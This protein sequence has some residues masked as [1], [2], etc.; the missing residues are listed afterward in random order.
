[1]NRRLWDPL[2][3]VPI[4]GVTG[5]NGA[6]K[7]LLAVQSALADLQRGRVVYSTTPIHSRWGDSVPITSIS[8]LLDLP[9]GC[10]VLIDEVASV[11]S[12]RTSTGLPG[13]FDLF[14]QVLRHRGIAFR[15]TAP[16]WLRAD[17]RLREVTQGL[18]AVSPL[19]RRP[20]PE[21]SLWP[22]TIIAMCAVLDTVGVKPDATPEDV[23]RRR[24][25]RLAGLPAFGAYDTH[26][27]VESLVRTAL[28]GTCPDC[29]GSRARPKCDGAR[30]H[31]LGLTPPRV[32]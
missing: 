10:T 26:Q 11:F 19:I 4:A 29:G 23:K 30:H 3:G 20:D 32:S 17:N 16:A 14:V 5:V 7:T 18:L 9:H 12:S 13:E 24:F 15:W 1:M 28:F 6:G 27:H 2:R 8:Q 22:R 25:V 21:G 31:G